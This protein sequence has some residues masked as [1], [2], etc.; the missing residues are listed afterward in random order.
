[1]DNLATSFGMDDPAQEARIV[2]QLKRE[3]NA[4]VIDQFG[5]LDLV[6]VC[7][8]AID[9]GGQ[10]QYIQLLAIDRRWSFRY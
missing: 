4:R 6:Q 3:A 5:G 1:M 8:I 2:R 10:R 9:F 7:H